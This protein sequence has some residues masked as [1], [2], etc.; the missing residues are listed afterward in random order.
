MEDDLNALFL[1]EQETEASTRS[2]GISRADFCM[3]LIREAIDARLKGRGARMLARE[4]LRDLKANFGKTESESLQE[5]LPELAQSGHSTDAPC[6]E[7]APKKSARRKA[8]RFARKP[9]SQK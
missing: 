5:S 9:S 7:E 1:Q 6:K 3:M 2:P 4:T 8:T